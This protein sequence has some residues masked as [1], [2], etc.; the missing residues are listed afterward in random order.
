MGVAGLV[1]SERMAYAGLTTIAIL[2]SLVS[3]GLG[4]I[5][6]AILARIIAGNCRERGIE[7]HFPLLV[8]SAYC[9]HVVGMQGL[10]SSIALVLN[11]PGHFLEDELGLI[12]LDQTIFSWWS[13]SI[14]AAILVILPQVLARVAPDRVQIVEMLAEA[15]GPMG[16][17]ER[18]KPGPGAS[19]SENWKTRGG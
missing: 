7:V 3:W 12:G 14:I 1:R 4:L 17:E 16:P 9:G 11:T 19:P 10:S 5:V 2:A 8:A 18:I 13:L 6:P 15:G